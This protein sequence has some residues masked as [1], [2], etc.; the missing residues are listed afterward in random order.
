M[1]SPIDK[2]V[3]LKNLSIFSVT[4]IA[5]AIGSSSINTNTNELKYFLSMYLSIILNV[6]EVYIV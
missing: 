5:T 1:I 6:N 2:S 3:C 4:S